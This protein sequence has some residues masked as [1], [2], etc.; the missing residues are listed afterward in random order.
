MEKFN[1]I[2]NPENRKDKEYLKIL[3][4]WF[5]FTEVE[6]TTNDVKIQNIILNDNRLQRIYNQQIFKKDEY[7]WER[8]NILKE[9]I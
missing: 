5:L 7:N 9:R 3:K 1:F 2:N 8:A 6:L 4:K